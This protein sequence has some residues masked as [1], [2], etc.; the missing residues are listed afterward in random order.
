MYV[1]AEG[2]LPI[3]LCA[4]MDTVFPKPPKTF[5]YDQKKSVLWSPEGVGADDRAGNY[6]IIELLE[7]GYRPSIILTD[8]EEEGGIGADALT[9]KYPDCPFADC[10]ALIQLDRQGNNDAVYYDCNNADFEEKITSYGFKTNWGTFT[11]ISIFGPQWRIAAVNLS[12]GYYNEHNYIETL[13]MI[14]LHQTIDRVG[15]ILKD[16]EDW[17]AYAYIPYKYPANT[18]FSDWWAQKNCICCGKALKADE[19]HLC[20]ATSRLEDDFLVCDDCYSAYFFCVPLNT[21]EI[22]SSQKIDI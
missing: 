5:Y 14:E 7:R 17:L 15:N 11:D 1:I 20:G 4:H 8:L 3:C 22:E 19:G 2:D 9:K 6:A 12:V 18:N 21:T 13:N 10:R 16:C